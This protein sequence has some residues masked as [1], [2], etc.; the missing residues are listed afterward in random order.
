[1]VSKGWINK[2]YFKN[3]IFDHPFWMIKKRPSH[4]KIVITT[5]VYFSANHEQ[6]LLTFF[7]LQMEYAR[8]NGRPWHSRNLG[9]T[10]TYYKWAKLKHLVRFSHLQLRANLISGIKHNSYN[11]LSDW[12]S[13]YRVMNRKII[14]I[15][16]IS[17]I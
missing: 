12:S 11:I 4:H 5:K 14:N 6:H 10:F 8:R 17:F 16:L 7:G 2:N 1:M 13:F 3:L 15:Q 9:G